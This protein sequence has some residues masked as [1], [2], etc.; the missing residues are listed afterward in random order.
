MFFFSPLLALI[1]EQ[2]VR[3]G[4]D[5]AHEFPVLQRSAACYRRSFPFRW[6]FK[7]FPSL[8]LA[9]AMPFFSRLALASADTVR[10]PFAALLLLVLVV[11]VLLLGEDIDGRLW[12]RKTPGAMGCGPPGDLTVPVLNSGS[13]RLP[14]WESRL[15][16]GELLS[17]EIFGGSLTTIAFFL[18]LFFFFLVFCCSS[19]WESFAA[20]AARPVSTEATRAPSL[21]GRSCRGT[22]GPTRAVGLYGVSS[23]LFRFFDLDLKTGLSSSDSSEG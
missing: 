17:W 9:V 1:S 16:S 10:S 6:I 15:C 2:G 12:L 21:A 19:W 18:V 8:C 13:V 22:E 7:I 5:P 11:L 4:W 3:L 14:S 20:A 23:L